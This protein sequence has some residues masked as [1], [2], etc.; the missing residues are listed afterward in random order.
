MIKELI[1]ILKRLSK[2]K[3][4]IEANLNKSPLALGDYLRIFSFLPNLSY[5]KI[6]IKS[7]EALK[8]L[9]K[10]Y[11]FIETIDSRKE[12]QGQFYTMNLFE[13]KKNDLDNFYI[14]NLFDESLNVKQNMSEIFFKLV[15]FFKLTDYKIYHPKKKRDKIKYKVFFSC[16]APD[17]WK[18]K[19]YPKNMWDMLYKKLTN[20]N[21]ISVKFQDKN[22]SL[23]QFIND[24]K[25][26]EIIVSIV[27]LGC[28]LSNALS[29]KLI[30][31]SG[32]NYHTESRYEKNQIT[33]FPDNFCKF[34]PCNL[35]NGVQNCGCMGDIDINKIY[36]QI[37][38]ML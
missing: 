18:I 5:Q 37:M 23:D 8:P 31:L 4:L 6:F 25:S 22:S 32:P 12:I 24:I 17:E 19:E 3:L 9:V 28:H 20:G 21:K 27:N 30:M 34:R 14:L 33:I 16:Y 35:P 2:K 13:K 36:Y 38:K 10:I 15:K 11:D 29:K 26:A 7:D 1:L